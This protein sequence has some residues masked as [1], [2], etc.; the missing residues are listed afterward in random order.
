MPYGKT[1]GRERMKVAYIV[2]GLPFGGIERWLY[3]LLLE[4][5]RNGLVEGRVFNL[6]GT[7]DLMPQ[8]LEAGLPVECVANGLRAIASHRFDTSLKLRG[9][10]KSYAPDIIHTV[11]FTGNHHGRIA[12]LG[13]GIPV[14][15]HLRNTKHE[16]TL[17]RRFS[18]KALSYATTLYLA[19]SKAVAEVVKTDHN[20]AKR[21]VRVLY[22]AFNPSRMDSAPLDMGAAYGLTG[23]IIISVCR[24][25]PQKNLD[26]LVRALRLLHDAGQKA[27]LVL[28][29]EGPERGKLEALARDLDLE[30]HV[31]LAGFQQDV[32]SFYK[33]AH[34]FAMPSDFEGFLIAMLEAMYCALP[35]VV[36]RHVPLL[37]IASDAALVCR[38]DP[39]DIAEKLARILHDPELARTLGATARS[40]AERYT[41]ENYARELFS[42]YQDIVNPRKQGTADA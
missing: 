5:R 31:L 38:R 21:P 25:V 11:H 8:Y 4:Y 9:L 2:G 16:R 24:Y 6:S 34:I 14:I 18:D 28:V 41:M 30:K 3:D 42:I 26:L 1:G 15:T 22:N 35:S 23:P 32:A 19:V 12:A 20:I 40:I 10:L 7:G 36:S 17:N 13:L 29:G 39:A 37:E 27:S 33:A